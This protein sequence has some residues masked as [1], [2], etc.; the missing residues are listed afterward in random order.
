MDKERW[1]RLICVWQLWNGD[2]DVSTKSEFKAT[3]H[4]LDI[5]K[6]TFTFIDLTQKK[7]KRTCPKTRLCT[8]YYQLIQSKKHLSH[9]QI[10]HSLSEH[11]SFFFFA[12]VCI[13]ES[14]YFIYYLAM[15][16]Q[17]L[18]WTLKQ[19]HLSGRCWRNVWFF[20]ILPTERGAKR[21]HAVIT[22]CGLY[23]TLI[24]FLN[25]HPHFFC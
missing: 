4:I 22:L 7:W 5:E 18:H 10:H 2:I 16:Y 23:L 14:I 21:G 17:N 20:K 3:E 9:P 25:K 13:S 1:N 15:K 6:N 8:M 12:K 11:T 24:D 19:K